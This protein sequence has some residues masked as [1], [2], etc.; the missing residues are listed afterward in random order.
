MRVLYAFSHLIDCTYVYKE[1]SN[2]K[3]NSKHYII[4]SL[5]QGAL[6]VMLFICETLLGQTAVYPQ[7]FKKQTEHHVWY[8]RSTNM[9]C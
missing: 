6:S 5:R 4:V 2:K 9:Q 7:V 1:T 3:K 8:Y